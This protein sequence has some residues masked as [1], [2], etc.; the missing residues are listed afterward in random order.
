M[1]T[2][3]D[4]K[5]LNCYEMNGL[6][7]TKDHVT[8]HKLFL[9]NIPELLNENQLLKLFS[10]IGCVLS[11][12]IYGKFQGIQLSELPPNA[13]PGYDRWMNCPPKTDLNIGCVLF[14]SPRDAAKALTMAH[15]SGIEYGIGILASDSWN[16]PQ[17]IEDPQNDSE[18]AYILR[19]PDDCL[20][21]IISYLS[22]TDRLHFQR[23]CKRFRAVYE[24]HT[25]CLHKSVDFDMFHG[26]TLWNI[27]DFLH[28]S[29]PY[30]VDFSASSLQRTLRNDRIIKYMG[31]SCMN[32]TT[33]NLTDVGLTA[34]NV[35]Q[36]VA[37]ANKLVNLTLMRCDLTDDKL[38][39]LK[40]LKNLKK[41]NLRYNPLMG[42]CLVKLS[43]SIESLDVSYCY[44]MNTN[45]LNAMCKILTN[46]KELHIFN[47]NIGFP[48]KLRCLSLEL[49]RL[50]LKDENQCEQIA[51]LPKLK[52]L[53]IGVISHDNAHTKIFDYLIIYKS[54]QLEKL[55]IYCCE[56]VTKKMFT[57][58][59]K[60]TGLK[61]LILFFSAYIDDADIDELTKLTNL[62]SIALGGCH[63][64]TDYSMMRLLLQCPKLQD[65]HLKKCSKI[66]DELVYNIVQE[67]PRRYKKNERNLPINLYLYDTKI[68]VQ[69][70]SLGSAAQDIIK[71]FYKTRSHWDSEL[72]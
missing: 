55:V 40:D 22:L 53:H 71:I 27:R 65:V 15:A 57:Q 34:R 42:Y 23:T 16:Q 51:K 13:L 47:V 52:D 29:G 58:I 60:L 64:I 62:E 70:S 17:F 14:A 1:P 19:I 6:F 2:T 69:D 24:L 12:Q 41:V 10:Q 67:I 44:K 5:D 9:Y 20:L 54:D 68:K 50:F 32:L 11:V 61:T 39:A 49:L 30:V 48:G 37:T 28:L 38:M 59:A 21:R 35:N 45:C 25:R 3:F 18:E 56:G 66:T 8:V 46:L 31:R 72:D 4:I 33:L 36:I 7:Y 26:L 43:H 63:S